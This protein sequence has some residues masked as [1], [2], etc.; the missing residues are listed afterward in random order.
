LVSL[1][2]SSLQQTTAL[3]QTVSGS[4]MVSGVLAHEMSP[5]EAQTL[6]NS[7]IT[8]VS[9]D[10]TFNPSDI[11]NWYKVYSLAQQYNLSVVGILDQH[12]MNYSNTFTLADWSNAVTQAVIAFGSVV[13]TWEIWNEPNYPQNDLGY[14]NGTAQAYVSML[15]TA[16]SDIKAIASSDT[17]IGLGGMP[18]Y[19]SDNPTFSD[20][21]AMQA[22]AWTQ[23]VVQLGGMSYCDVIAVHAYPYGPYYPEIAGAS[24]QYYVQQYSQLCNKPIWVTEVGQES[25]STTWP[26]TESQQSTFLAQSYSLFQS[27][28][29]KAYIWYE[30][31]DNYTAIPGSNFG[32]FDNNGNPKP[33]FDTFVNEVN[34][35][36]SPTATPTA[37]ATPKPTQNPTPSPTQ[38]PTAIPTPSLTPSPSP[39]PSPTATTTFVLP[40]TAA[41]TCSSSE[42]YAFALI[43]GIAVAFVVAISVYL[44]K[45]PPKQSYAQAR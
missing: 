6:A 44:M 29:V 19:T 40:P 5:V 43:V 15:Q 18:L 3:E 4:T 13:K 30:L 23:Q 25:Y 1:A 38:N 22:Y 16:Y 41:P 10:V 2:A 7:N 42:S 37:T 12:L 24:F 34:G 14:F 8:W 31:N 36:R 39:S 32:L 26:A 11:S 9:C 17:V 21:Y 27:L 45:R 28:G 20:T 33:A 35:V